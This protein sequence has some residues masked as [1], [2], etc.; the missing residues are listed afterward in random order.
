MNTV[1]P[2][3]EAATSPADAPNGP[4]TAVNWCPGP[5]MDMHELK[6]I[7][8]FFQDIIDRRK[9]FE[10]R[11]HDRCFRPGDVLHLREWRPNTERYSGR[12]CL[13]GVTYL[14]HGGQFG[15][16]IGTCIL[17]IT[18]P[19]SDGR[20]GPSADSAVRNGLNP[21]SVC[22]HPF[23]TYVDAD[24]WRCGLCGFTGSYAELT[25]GD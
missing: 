8:P 16:D 1:V 14:M 11:R 23:A 24:L 21:E 4:V 2:T 7:D 17:G 25:S 12:E 6:T 10:V 15:I 5:L 13:V 20:L 19:L 3:V 9:T 18:P 22:H